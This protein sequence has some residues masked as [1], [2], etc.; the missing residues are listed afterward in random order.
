VLYSSIYNS[1]A[2]VFGNIRPLVGNKLYFVSSDAEISSSVCSLADKRG[3]KNIYVSPDYLSDDLLT[4]KS[5]EVISVIDTL[6]RQNTLDF[7]VACFHYQSYNLTKNLNERIPSVII[8]ILIFGT[9]LFLVKRKNLI[10]FSTAAALSGFEIIILLILQTAAGNMYLL[11]GLVIASLMAGLATGAVINLKI[12]ETSLIRLAALVLIIFY[13][14]TGL[15]FNQLQTAGNN[16]ISVI[17]LLLLIFIPSLITGQLFR[18]MT[19]SQ[20][21]YSDASSVYGADLAGSALGFII[22][23]GLALP[24]L[25]IRMTIILLSSMIFAAF[26]F[27]TNS[28]K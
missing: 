7:P 10:M 15:L 22:V 12:A 19:S 9:P 5:D 21:K 25:G 2:A 13:V 27:G 8:L 11:T 24:V 3:I 18:T 14:C 17:I 1:L 6:V 16:T 4:K 28:N 23:S 26:L 20:L